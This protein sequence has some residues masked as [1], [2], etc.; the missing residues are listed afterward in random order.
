[1]RSQALK[2]MD[3]CAASCSAVNDPFLVRGK[4]D[5]NVL[6]IQSIWLDSRNVADRSIREMVRK[7]E[8]VVGARWI[9]VE[10]VEKPEAGS[11][12][13]VEQKGRNEAALKMLD[14]WMSE[15]PTYDLETW[16]VVKKAIDEHRLS[17]RSRFD[18]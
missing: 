2:T 17:D 15:D 7:Q 16:P 3:S 13:L 14:R 9:R 4:P 6:C 1:M 5:R 8:P 10:I 12:A 18:G 11:E